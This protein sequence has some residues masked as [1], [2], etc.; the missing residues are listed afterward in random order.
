MV[1][2]DTLD[3]VRHRSSASVLTVIHLNEVEDL[4]WHD[5]ENV[6]MTDE[7][8]AALKASVADLRKKTK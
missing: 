4:A 6:T 8:M 1:V 7:D 5:T 3:Q 2:M